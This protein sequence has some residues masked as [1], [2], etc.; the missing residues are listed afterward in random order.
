MDP[1]KVWISHALVPQV[2]KMTEE[3][4][5]AKILS[6]QCPLTGDIRQSGPELAQRMM[7]IG[8]SPSS[9]QTH[10]FCITPTSDQATQ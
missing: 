7:K 2:G 10:P 1:N 4:P 9:S 8:H 3:S 5:S 6:S